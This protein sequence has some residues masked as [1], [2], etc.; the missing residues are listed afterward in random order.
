MEEYS[1]GGDE[2]GVVE[3]EDEEV[4][5]YDVIPDEDYQVQ[6]SVV[7]NWPYLKHIP[8]VSSNTSIVNILEINGLRFKKSSSLI[9]DGDSTACE[10]Y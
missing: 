1:E 7:V 6:S 4:D 3:A 10:N 2:E 8:F 5:D 9:G